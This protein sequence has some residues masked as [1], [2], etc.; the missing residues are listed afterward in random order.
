MVI[1]LVRY[2]LGGLL[3]AEWNIYIYVHKWPSIIQSA[4]CEAAKLQASQV[5]PL[6]L[7]LSE[8]QATNRRFGYLGIM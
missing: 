5:L 8:S 2:L 6:V 1:I 3:I 4:R 7:T